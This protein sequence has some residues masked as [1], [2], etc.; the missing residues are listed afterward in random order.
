MA[1]LPSELPQDIFKHSYTDGGQTGCAVSRSICDTSA[2]LRYQS[3]A[4]DSTR[5]IRTFNQL[6]QSNP[7]IEKYKKEG[8]KQKEEE[9]EEEENE[10]RTAL[11]SRKASNTDLL[12]KLTL[13][14]KG[15][16][17]SNQEQQKDLAVK[18]AEVAILYL[19]MH[20]ALSLEHLYYKQI[21]STTLRFVPVPLPA[22]TELTPIRTVKELAEPDHPPRSSL[23]SQLSFLER[24]YLVMNHPTGV[25]AGQMCLQDMTLSLTL[26][27]LSDVD[28]FELFLS[29]LMVSALNPWPSPTSSK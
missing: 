5:R 15:M 26:V 13:L 17:D 3:L 10:K 29:L 9:E 4:L 16:Y 11:G 7:E 8:G 1:H 14:L 21:L 6:L 12:S 28:W 24:L 19:F 2:P 18:S 27:R 22:L 23:R 20:V 25:L